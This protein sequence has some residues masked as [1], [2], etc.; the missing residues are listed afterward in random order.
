MGRTALLDGVTLSVPPGARLL[1]VSRPPESASLLL[2]VLAG[3]ARVDHGDVEMAGTRDRSR[4]GWAR[5]VAYVGPKP[6]FYPWM[7][8]REVLSLAAELQGLAELDAKRR[9]ADLA[10][11]MGVAPVL[12]QPTSRGGPPVQQR[13]A[14]AAALVG[15]PEVLLLDE[16]LRALDPDERL[17]LLRFPESRGAVLLA[18]RYPASEAGLCAHVALVAEGRLVLL[19]PVSR[20]ADYGLPLSLQGIEALAAASRQ[21]HEALRSGAP[22]VA[23]PGR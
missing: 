18:S 4:A 1:V 17:R 20:L 8:P 10:E 3:L 14:L 13:V 16:P 19:A 15:D 2:R 7:T 21:G 6:G 12:D 23:M 22:R 11:R 9:V 5:R